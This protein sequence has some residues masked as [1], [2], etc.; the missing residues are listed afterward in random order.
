MMIT[1]QLP[2]DKW[3][4]LTGEPIIAGTIADRLIHHDML[5]ATIWHDTSMP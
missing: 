3:H 2:V 4:A 1:A 5:Q